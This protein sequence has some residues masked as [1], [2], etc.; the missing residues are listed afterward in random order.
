MHAARGRVKRDL[1]IEDTRYILDL[2][3]RVVD[4]LTG[5]AADFDGTLDD[6]N[7]ILGNRGKEVRVF[8]VPGAV[9]GD[10][11]LHLRARVGWDKFTE[12]VSAF[13]RRAAELD[14]I[15]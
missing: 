11:L 9:V 7:R 3:E 6:I 1:A 2:R 5:G 8:V 15:R 12:D 14:I 13:C 4:A 10:E